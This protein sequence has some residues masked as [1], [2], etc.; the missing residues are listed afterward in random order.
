M[1]SEFDIQLLYVPG[2]RL[3]LPDV[4]SRR[5]DYI[6]KNDQDN[7]NETLLPDHLFVRVATVQEFNE[8][9]PLVVLPDEL[10]TRMVDAELTAEFRKGRVAEPIVHDSIRALKGKGP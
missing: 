9:D 10:F 7:E 5:S 2:S 4:L 1:L 6:P 3:A 8:E